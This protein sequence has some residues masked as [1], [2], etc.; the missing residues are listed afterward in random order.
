MLKKFEIAAT[1]T[2]ANTYSSPP[3]FTKLWD[4]ERQFLN[5]EVWQLSVS[6]ALPYVKA[7]MKR[8]NMQSFAW[9]EVECQVF[10]L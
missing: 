7:Q 4:A 10:F 5:L 9:Y 8:V 1:Y 6:G 2:L 3:S